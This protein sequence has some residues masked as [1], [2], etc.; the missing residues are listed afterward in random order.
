MIASDHHFLLDELS[1]AL[2]L[3]K[4]VE[5]DLDVLEVVLVAALGVNGLQQ[6]TPG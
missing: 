1:K 6:Q 3:H 2:G 5:E 4:L